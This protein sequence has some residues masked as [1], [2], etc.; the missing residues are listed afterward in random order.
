[1][2]QQKHDTNIVPIQLSANVS[3]KSLRLPVIQT[4]MYTAENLTI[5]KGLMLSVPWYQQLYIGDQHIPWFN[6]EKINAFNT[7]VNAGFNI[8]C[9][10]DSVAF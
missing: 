8:H 1:M 6:D 4:E 3:R 7:K 2:D 10:Y 9:V 5:M